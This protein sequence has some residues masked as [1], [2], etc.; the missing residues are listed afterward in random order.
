MTPIVE[1]IRRELARIDWRDELKSA[2]TTF[3]VLLPAF[4]MA[5]IQAL[6]EGDL[7]LNAFMAVGLAV[8]RTIVKTVLTI[9]LPKVFPARNSK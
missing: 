9:V 6:Y 2:F 1:K 5:S 3:L 8:A 7:S 4:E